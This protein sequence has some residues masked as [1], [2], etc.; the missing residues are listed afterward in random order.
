MKP[1]ELVA[2]AIGRERERAGLSLSALAAK[3]GLAKS[4]LSQL[5]AGKGNPSIETMWAIAS[6]LQVPFSFLFESTT[7]QSRVLRAQESVELP[8]EVS[9]YSV[10]LLAKCPPAIRRDLYRVSLKGGRVRTA[11]AHPQG[12]VEHA[13]ICDGSVRLGPADE[14][15]D[16]H[17]GDYFRYPADVPHSYEALTESAIIL[18][19]MESPR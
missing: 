2:S 3:A 10:A 19:I 15:E 4:T 9:E 17:P 5:E 11:E 18:L 14:A 1:T 6:A 12:T 16:L 13:I 7:S 8:A